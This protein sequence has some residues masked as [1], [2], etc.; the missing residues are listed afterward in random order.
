MQQTKNVSHSAAPFFDAVSRRTVLQAMAAAPA[1]LATA[2][3]R[4]QQERTHRAYLAI[5]SRH[6]QWTGWQEGIEVAIETGYPGII[7]SVRGGA[8]VEPQNVARELPAIVSATRE[9]GLAVPMIITRIGDAGE[10]H[11][12]PMLETF[13]SLGIGRYRAGTPRYD[14]SRSF[15]DQFDEFRQNLDALQELNARY[16][17]T[18]C[19]HTHSSPGSLGGVGWDLWMLMRDCDPRYIGI[20]FDIGHI[21][22]RTGVGW[23]DIARAAREYIQS[24][25]LKDL[26][27]WRRDESG[28]RG[29]WPWDR[30]FVP[31]GD[32]MVPFADVFDFFY[33]TNFTGPMEVY[34]EYAAPIPGSE[35][36]LNMLGTNYG[37][38]Q[39]EVPRDYFISLL[40]RDVRFYKTALRNAGFEI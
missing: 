15:A 33:D 36:R 18:A 37:K 26:V 34:H 2:G 6:L 21:M 5:V 22:A 16:D 31:P 24:L 13:A 27:A 23:R 32:G 25:S 38:W 4:A 39:L 14:Y 12:E 1:A 17:V 11:I 35:D 20:N 7:W 30:Q 3:S 10:P 8:H 40:A 29:G 19:F 9:A 28:G